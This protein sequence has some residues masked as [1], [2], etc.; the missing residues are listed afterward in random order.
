MFDLCLTQDLFASARAQVS[1]EV[2]KDMLAVARPC[3]ALGFPD[4]GKEVPATPLGK[5][6]HAFSTG[7]ILVQLGDR[8]A[9]LSYESRPCP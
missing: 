5:V 2:L 7:S 6:V 8:T 3:E 1:T 9:L 4:I